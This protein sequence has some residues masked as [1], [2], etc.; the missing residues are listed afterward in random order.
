MITNRFVMAVCFG[1]CVVCAL[2]ASDE[3]SGRAARADVASVIGI[4][5]SSDV[6]FDEDDIGDNDDEIE[7]EKRAMPGVMRFGKR[8]DMPGVLRFGKKSMPGV[9]RFGKKAM[10]GVMRFGKKSMPGVMRFG[11]R[12]ADDDDRTSG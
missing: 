9:M 10:P 7:E 11:K 4:I 6:I 2:S 5:P 12:A 1:V 3:E 8:G